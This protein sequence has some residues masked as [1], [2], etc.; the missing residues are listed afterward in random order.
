MI[1]REETFLKDYA[2]KVNPLLKT[3]LAIKTKEASKVGKIPEKVLEKFSEMAFKGKKIRG[4]LVV[5]GYLL[6]NGKKLDEIYDASIF[7][8][9]FHTGILVHDDIIDKSDIRRGLTTIH[10]QFNTSL[11]LCVGDA[12]FFLAFEK[13]LD[14]NF[15]T[16][17]KFKALKLFSQY[18]SRLAY[19]QEL[20]IINNDI[21][22]V[23]EKDILDIYK[24]KTAEYTG[25]L[26]L[27]IGSTLAG[28][29][30]KKK[31]RNLYN[32]GLSLGWVFQITDDILGIFGEEK[33][34]GKSTS[35]D[36]S[37]GKITLLQFYL[38]KCGTREQKDLQSKLLGKKNIS[39]IDLEVLK[40]S[41]IDCG[42]LEYVTGKCSKYEKSVRKNLLILTKEYRLKK[43]IMNLVQYLIERKS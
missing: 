35:S 21:S 38:H 13:L 19:G 41:L 7:I 11:A 26:P 29:N 27:L 6:G 23:Q 22:K 30:D 3:F 33:E 10:K 18:A 24:Y 14:S 25:A 32:L 37:E 31:I 16:K 34:T 8:E 5:L 39:E 4:A 20:D 2:E 36:I 15:P 17:D 42:A 9:I 43:I 1:G 40:K 28:L 12:A